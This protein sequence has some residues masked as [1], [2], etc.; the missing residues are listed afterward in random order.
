MSNTID[1][2]SKQTNGIDAA[3][4]SDIGRIRSRNQD[5]FLIADLKRLLTIHDSNLPLDDCNRLFGACTGY[6]LVVADGMGGH[7]E[8][9][10]A[11]TTAVEL[12]ARYTLDMMHWFLKLSADSEDDFLEE[13]SDCLRVVQER[14]WSASGDSQHRMGTTVTIAY[15]LW[16]RLYLVHAGDSRCYLLRDSQLR[17]LTTDHTLAQQLIESGALSLEDAANSRWRH[18]LW[19]CVGGGDHVVQPEVS[20]VFLRNGDSIMLCSDGLTN[21]VDEGVI[22]S[23][24]QSSDSSKSAVR[25]LVDRANQNGGR[26]NTT[27][28]V[29][30]FVEGADS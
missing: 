3:G 11:S 18:V 30:R 4:I 27:V 16:P 29:A 28:V 13:L 21:M 9:D 19:N 25:E 12:C 24:L 20:K 6:L 26:D 7:Q 2:S 5:R 22:I 1:V 14:L 10:T 17:Q 8:G 15:V 23:V